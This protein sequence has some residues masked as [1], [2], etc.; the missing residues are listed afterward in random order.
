MIH[1]TS[2]TTVYSLVVSYFELDTFR[3]VIGLLAEV[4]KFKPLRHSFD[5]VF[6]G[7]RPE[8][9]SYMERRDRENHW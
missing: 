2:R 3:I 4:T 1:S 8:M 5:R 9:Q 7:H 6:T